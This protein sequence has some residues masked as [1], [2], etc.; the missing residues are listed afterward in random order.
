M[1]VGAT[2]I[3][4]HL[5]EAVSGLRARVWLLLHAVNNIRQGVALISL[6]LL[7]LLLITLVIV[8]LHRCIHCLEAQLL[9]ALIQLPD[10]CRCK[11]ITYMYPTSRPYP[12]RQTL[13]TG[14][15]DGGPHA[16]FYSSRESQAARTGWIGTVSG[17][18]IGCSSRCTTCHTASR[19]LH[20]A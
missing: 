14:F 6:L 12:D 19:S 8:P 1:T 17:C 7:R 4:G 18:T 3:A 13:I 16:V 10:L 5:F 11:R 2:I 20:D 15:A 9:A